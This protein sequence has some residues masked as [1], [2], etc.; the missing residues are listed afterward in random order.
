MI[1]FCNLILELEKK[2]NIQGTPDR[3]GQADT[4][5]EGEH[6]QGDTA[7]EEEHVQ[8]TPT[9][10]KI[11]VR[12]TKRCALCMEGTPGRKEKSN[13]KKVQY[14][15]MLGFNISFDTVITK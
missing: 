14:R 2:Y 15:F 1:G 4:V 7:D 9:T 11:R 13:L 12:A 5:D 10:P 6:A 8:N 3:R